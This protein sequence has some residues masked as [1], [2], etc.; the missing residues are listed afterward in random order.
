MVVP[1]VK[2]GGAVL[3]VVAGLLL[4]DGD[5]VRPV[6]AA[7][8]GAV[9]VTWA[10]RDLVA[11]VRLAVDPDGVTVVRGFAA[12]RHLPWAAVE[13]VAVD[14]RRRFGVSTGTLEVD[15]GDQLHLFGRYDLGADPVEVAEQL[16]AA[17][18]RATAH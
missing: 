9:L 4:A 5:P 10:V 12:R 14:N 15:T 16:R 2:L 18:A 13:R 17:A 6:L 3:L 1:V 7:L 8:V 11:P